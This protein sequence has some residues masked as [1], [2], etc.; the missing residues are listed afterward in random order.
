MRCACALLQ[1]QQGRA[2]IVAGCGTLCSFLCTSSTLLA[3][4]RLSG[5]GCSVG[6]LTRRLPGGSIGAFY[7]VSTGE[8]GAPV[9]GRCPG[10][11]PE[12]FS[13]EP[14]SRIWVGKLW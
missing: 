8:E 11:R 2:G 13:A 6:K 9:V 4:E 5:R 12:Q 14:A 10:E 1:A 3:W 7:D